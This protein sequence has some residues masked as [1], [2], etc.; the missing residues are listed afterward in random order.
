MLL[1]NLS[2]LHLFLQTPHRF[3]FLVIPPLTSSCCYPTKWLMY[4]TS[5]AR[6][7]GILFLIFPVWWCLPSGSVHYPFCQ[8]DSGSS[9]WWVTRYTLCTEAACCT[10]C[11]FMSPAISLGVGILEGSFLDH[12]FAGL[13]Q[14]RVSM[15]DPRSHFAEDYTRCRSISHPSD[16]QAVAVSL[17]ADLELI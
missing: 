2:V 4:W 7:Q 9:P 5:K 14:S 10:G 15:E 3:P 13:H 11:R 12:L 8:C 17:A 16:R 6:G 1:W